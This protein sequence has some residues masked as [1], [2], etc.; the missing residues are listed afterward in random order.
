MEKSRIDL[1]IGITLD[2][3]IKSNQSQYPHAAGAFSQLLRDLAL[4]SK[5][6]NREI[7]KAGLIDIMGYVGIMN[8]AGDNQQKL[9]LLANTRFTRALSKGGEAGGIASE[10]TDSFVDLNNNGKYIVTI[11]P[12]DGSSNIDV[13]VS[14]GT[15]FSI[16]KKLSPLDEPLVEQDFL[17]K[18]RQQIAAGYILYGSSTMF[19]YSTGNGVN[20]FTYE[21]TLGEY[22][23]SHP[24]IQF[25]EPC[26]YF[27]MNEALCLDVIDQEVM[28][29]ISYCKE[30]AQEIGEKAF[31]KN[32]IVN[33]EIEPI[34]GFSDDDERNIEKMKGFLEKEYEKSPVKTYLTKGGNKKEV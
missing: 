4:A 18:G 22:V 13:N 20:G 28:N 16:Y 32:D 25:G 5:V 30:M 6:V 19:V 34:I 33:N 27:S 29:F 12:L 3:F 9:D 23:L 24:D 11:D 8:S 31:F 10:E 2:R 1:P 7:N 15:I 26:T 17:Q 14:V 21:S